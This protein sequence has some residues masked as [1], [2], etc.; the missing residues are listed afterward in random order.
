MSWADAC[1]GVIAL[2]ALTSCLILADLWRMRCIDRQDD[3]H[4]TTG[5]PT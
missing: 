4:T 1:L 2:C 3:I 5:D